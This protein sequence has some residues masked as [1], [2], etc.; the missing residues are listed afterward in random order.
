MATPPRWFTDTG[1]GHSQWYVDHFRELATAGEDLE[2]EARMIDAMVP[3]Q[4]R[5]LDAGCGQGR[6]GAALFPRG[7]QVV[8]IDADPF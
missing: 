2:G 3:R 4:A 6:T 8:G 7:H 5:I 1:E